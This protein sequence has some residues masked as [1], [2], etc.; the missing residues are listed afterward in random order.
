VPEQRSKCIFWLWLQITTAP[1]R[2][3]EWSTTKT[4]GG[5]KEFTE[6]GR[7]LIL[8][9]GRELPELRGSSRS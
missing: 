3:M 1:S 5:L 7:R 2:M 8:V 4:I 6:S 9:T